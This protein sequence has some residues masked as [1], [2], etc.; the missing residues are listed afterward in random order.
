[1]K[2]EKKES[3]DYHRHE[4]RFKCCYYQKEAGKSGAC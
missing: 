1:M 2:K 4:G 3:G